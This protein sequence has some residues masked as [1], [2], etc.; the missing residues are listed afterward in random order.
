[1]TNFGYSPTS[2]F[3]FVTFASNELTMINII[4]TIIIFILKVYTVHAQSLETTT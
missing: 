2:H 4:I 1:M 3:G